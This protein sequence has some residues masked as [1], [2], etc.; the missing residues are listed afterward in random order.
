MQKL[1]FTTSPEDVGIH[2]P[3]FPPYVSANF[4]QGE[5]A[6]GR[7]HVLFKLLLEIPKHSLIV[8]IYMAAFITDSLFLPNLY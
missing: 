5:T 6:D 1:S 3:I 4:V 8:L 7:I 2:G